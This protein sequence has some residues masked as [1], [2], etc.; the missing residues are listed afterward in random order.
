MGYDHIVP[1]FYDDDDIFDA[2]MF[3]MLCAGTLLDKIK[4]TLIS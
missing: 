3:V 4:C 2:I 1:K